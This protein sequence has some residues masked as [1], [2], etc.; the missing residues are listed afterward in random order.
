MAPMPKWM[1]ACF[2]IPPILVVALYA[3]VYYKFWYLPSRD[4]R[5]RRR[6]GASAARRSNDF[7]SV[8]SSS[9]AI[10]G[11]RRSR[12]DIVHEVVLVNPKDVGRNGIPFSAADV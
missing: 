9:E 6:L 7:S 3:A 12:E 11:D 4:K 10:E 5:R 2:I 1:Y 8:M